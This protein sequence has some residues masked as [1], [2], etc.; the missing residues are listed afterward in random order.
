[1]KVEVEERDFSNFELFEQKRRWG[2]GIA[3]YKL[4]NGK[5]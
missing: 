2:K 5:F 4:V 1:V 3:T